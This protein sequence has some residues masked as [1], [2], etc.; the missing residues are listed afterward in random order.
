MSHEDRSAMHEAMEQ[1]TISISKANIQATLISRTTILA[2]ANPKLGRFD[3]FA[4]LGEQID[5]PPTLI[6][7]FDLIFPIR[8][9]SDKDKDEK[10]ASHILNLHQEPDVV[11]QDID[12]QLLKKYVSYA[13]RTSPKL[14]DGA[15][16]EIKSYYAK[17][18]GSSSTEDGASRAIPISARQLEALVRLAESSARL[19]LSSKVTRKDAKRGIDLLHYCLTQV[20][21]DPDTGKIDIDRI[22]T[23]I[24]ATERGRIVTI[25]DI[26]NELENSIG[27]TIPIEDVVRAAS[28]RNLDENDVE[29][30]VEKLKRSGDIFEPKRGFISKI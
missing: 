14:T 29:E 19:R 21:L 6:N 12:T 1:Q 7:R 23:G 22:S 28:E 27:K 3:P 4:L 9:L 11:N 18:R 25:K 24:P 13:R 10:I 30:V 2:A 16:E 8:D 5:L 26:I 17:M 20:G 15:I